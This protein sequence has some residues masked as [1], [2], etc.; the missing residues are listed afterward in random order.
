MLVLADVAEVVVYSMEGT[1]LRAPRMGEAGK[2][3]KFHSQ[4]S[5]KL[6]SFLL[7]VF[8]LAREQELCSTAWKLCPVPHGPGLDQSIIVSVTFWRNGTHRSIGCKVGCVV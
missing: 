2:T 6:P 7:Y 1:A 5:P 4:A 3:L 8:S